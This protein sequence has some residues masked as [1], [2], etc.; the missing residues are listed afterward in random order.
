MHIV[1]MMANN[2]ANKNSMIPYGNTR[3]NT[4]SFHDPRATRTNSDKLAGDFSPYQLA[5]LVVATDMSVER[6][7]EFLIRVIHAND[8][9]IAMKVSAPCRSVRVVVA[10]RRPPA[11]P[12][13]DRLVA[14]NKQNHARVYA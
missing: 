4:S 7:E 11:A 8:L 3:I 5:L 13:T 10:P 6:A 9:N 12:G 1:S 2:A 14:A